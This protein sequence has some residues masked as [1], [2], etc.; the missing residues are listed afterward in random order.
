[1]QVNYTPKDVARFWKKVDKSSDLNGC[2]LWTGGCN[3]QGYGNISWNRGVKT[4]VN[5]VSY[6][7][8][9]GAF[10]DDLWVLHKCDNPRCVNPEH[11]FLG[12][13]QQ[14]IDD[15][16]SKNRQIRGEDHLRSKLTDAQVD[17]I[18]KR[19]SNGKRGIQRILA[20]EF[21]VSVNHIGRI[22]RFEFRKY[23]KATPPSQL[24]L[25]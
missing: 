1:M 6:L 14:N 22:V 24:D 9:N 23:V 12:T 4:R 13:R 3:K 16:V 2:W 11:L 5:R 21:R 7:L 17:E 19:C 18:R 25:F 10:D 20:K 15:M 8:A